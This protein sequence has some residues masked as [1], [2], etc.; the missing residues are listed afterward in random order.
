MGVAFDGAW[1]DVQ[2]S[3]DIFGPFLTVDWVRKKISKRII[4]MAKRGEFDADTLRDGALDD[5]VRAVCVGRLRQQP[6]L[7][8]SSDG[9][10]WSFTRLPLE[11]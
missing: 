2:A 3:G 1:E 10:S 5:L 6:N 4:N 9:P 7:N 8:G 11:G